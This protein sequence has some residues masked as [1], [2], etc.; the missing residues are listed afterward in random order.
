VIPET[1]PEKLE[2]GETIFQKLQCIKCHQPSKTQA[3]GASFLAP[4]LA[5]AKDRLKP[6]WVVEWL[7]DP[8]GLQQGTMMPTFF[9]EGVTPLPD[10]LGGDTM[11]QIE[12]LRDHIFRYTAEKPEEP[13]RPQASAA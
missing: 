5:L 10:V 7:K 9:P 6:D 11:Q 3:L 4:D 1:T 12:A 8:Q 2:T 13:T